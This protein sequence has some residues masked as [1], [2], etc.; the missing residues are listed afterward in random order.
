MSLSVSIAP[1]LEYAT[2]LMLAAIFTAFA[3]SVKDSFWSTSLKLAAGLFWFVL[4]IGQ[5]IFFGGAG[6]F[7][8]LALPYGILGFLFF[9]AI[10][11]DSLSAKKHRQ[12]EF[13]DD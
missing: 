1:V 9:V 7:V 13:E 6:E 10:I 8:V 2:L 5:F 12:W 3:I 4:A 11:R